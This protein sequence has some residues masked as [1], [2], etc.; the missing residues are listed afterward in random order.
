MKYMKSKNLF[1][2]EDYSD[3]DPMNGIVNLFDISLVFI[4]TLLLTLFSVFNMGELLNE[5]SN[6]TIMKKSDNGRLEII[7]KKGKSIKAVKMSQTQAEGKGQ[8]LGTAY[9]LENGTMIYVPE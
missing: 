9:K 3:D 7:T 8:R 4:V 2:A 1:E 6:I 5:K